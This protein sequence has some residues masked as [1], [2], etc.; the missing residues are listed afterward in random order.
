MLDNRNLRYGLYQTVAQVIK[1]VTIGPGRLCVQNV[2]TG[3]AGRLT[4][5]EDEEDENED[6]VYA[7]EKAFSIEKTG[8]LRFQ[9]TEKNSRAQNEIARCSC[10][11]KRS[12]EDH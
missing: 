2:L 5:Y 10:E 9:C 8:S 7:E 1:V 11:G 12:C 6:D 4:E 3:R